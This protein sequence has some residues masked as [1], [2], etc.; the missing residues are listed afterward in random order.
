MLSLLIEV[1]RVIWY[2]HSVAVCL[3]ASGSRRHRVFTLLTRRATEV[4]PVAAAQ[5]WNSAPGGEGL[6]TTVRVEVGTERQGAPSLRAVEMRAAG[7][8]H[9]LAQG[10]LGDGFLP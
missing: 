8:L 10:H 1:A 3:E 7:L 9:V 2:V 5:T 6:R 4:S